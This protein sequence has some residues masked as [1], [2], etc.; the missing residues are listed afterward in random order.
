MKHMLYMASIVSGYIAALLWLYASQVKAV[1][2]EKKNPQSG[3]T[4]GAIIEDGYDVIETAKRQTWWNM[5]AALA[6]ALSVALQAI[7]LAVS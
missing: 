1:Y 7:S 4:S 3:W 2:H 5:W 6:T